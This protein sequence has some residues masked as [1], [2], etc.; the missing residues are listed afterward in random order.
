MKP[1]PFAYHA[2]ASLSE[3]IELL[4]EFEDEAK[5]LAGGQSLIPVL[6]M[7]LS[8]YEHLIDLR[9]IPGLVGVEPTS[10]GVRIGAM[11]TH[12]RAGRNPDVTARIPL[13]A[14][15]VPYIAHAAI[16]NR[17]TVGGSLAHAD[18]SA[19]HPAVALALDAEMEAVGPNGT[20]RISASEFFLSL[21]TTSL[22]PDE[23]LVAAH[24]PA[25]PGSCGFSV[26]EVARRHGDYA[27]AGAATGVQVTDGSVTRASIALF[28][29]AGTPLRAREAEQ[30]LL[31]MPAD[32]A[33][34]DAVVDLA[35]Q[36][37]EP[38]SDVHATGA[39]RVHMARTLLRRALA[40][41]IEEAVSV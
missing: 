20:R 37:V 41:S 17:G 1:A 24:Y 34:L 6:A 31:G 39:Q 28:S 10:Q 27:M 38:T 2:P 14:R 12:A 32:G 11:T 13:L 15:A 25:W 7:R 5:V 29:V 35:V 26:Q 8:Q 18:P 23:L 16:R 21:W 33:D 19:E 3:A 30:A 22:E 36:G 4:V 9:S 40:A